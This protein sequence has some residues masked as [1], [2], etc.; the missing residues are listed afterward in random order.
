MITVSFVLFA[1]LIFA[2][3]AVPDTRAGKSAKPVPAPA[4]VAVHAS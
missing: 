2:W 3:L 4:G 1:L